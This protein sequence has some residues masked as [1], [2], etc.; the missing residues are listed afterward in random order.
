MAK[1]KT[2]RFPLTGSG[3]PL[4]VVT[5]EYIGQVY[6]DTG[7]GRS[8][9]A[10]TLVN[11][12]WVLSPIASGVNYNLQYY[13][14]GDLGSDTLLTWDPINKFLGVG[15]AAPTS[16][17]QVSQSTAGAGVVA[18]SGTAV[19]GTNTKFLNTFKVGDSITATTTS[20]SETK[21]ITTVTSDTA[22][23]TEAFLGTAT[24]VAYT[25]V[26]GDRFVV[27]GNGQVG[28]GTVAPTAKAILDVASTTQGAMLP[29]MNTVQRDL[30]LTPPEGLEVYNTTTHQKEFYN[31]SAWK[32]GGVPGGNTTQVQFNNAGEFGGSAKMTWVDPTLTLTGGDVTLV[33]TLGAEMAPAISGVS[34]TNW[35]WTAN[36]TM[37]GS[38]FT[39]TLASG[40][41]TPTGTFTV[42]PGR[43]YKVVIGVSAVPPTQTDISTYNFQYTIGAA[44]G[45]Q[46]VVGTNTEYV[47]ANSSA[48]LIISCTSAGTAT[49]TS[50]SVMEVVSATGVLTTSVSPTFNSPIVISRPNVGLNEVPGIILANPTTPTVDQPYQHSPGLQFRS[51]RGIG[52]TD[53]IYD[54]MIKS[55]WTGAPETF[56]VFLS[57]NGA[58]WTNV[59]RLDVA[60]GLTTGNAIFGTTL[61]NNNSMTYGGGVTRNMGAV[62]ATTTAAT[63]V[64][65]IAYVTVSST[66]QIKAKITMLRANDYSKAGTFEIEAGFSH[67]TGTTVALIGKV[68]SLHN[69][70]TDSVSTNYSVNLVASGE[71][72][73]VQC[74]DTSAGT[75][76]GNTICKCEVEYFM[77]KQ[78]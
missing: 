33:P 18:V 60:G 50:I 61:V 9:E 72:I 35:T 43:T 77:T 10:T 45:S 30:I 65:T 56:G 58:A 38:T 26:G 59:L 23:V 75:A 44:K 78:S 66:M 47:V 14:T 70:V 31:G 53:Y 24:A 17:F 37:V 11:T 34:G 6:T 27:R 29:R 73:L 55:G 40:T 8:Y 51:H 15:V 19:T 76:P 2:G 12:G 48:K 57:S 39:K 52:A 5:P 13:S 32:S 64:L 49:I 74:T 4:S 28:I 16:N 62:S 21:L 46:L 69:Q 1:T 36:W 54:W 42:V 71:N 20:G 25:L 22:L 7:T 41:I 68:T 3:S 63:T 67:D